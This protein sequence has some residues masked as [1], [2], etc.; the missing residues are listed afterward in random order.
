MATAEADGLDYRVG[1]GTGVLAGNY[2][3]WGDTVVGLSD[4]ATNYVYVEDP[5]A[6]GYGD[7]KADTGSFPSG[8]LELWEVVTSSG[9]VDTETDARTCLINEKDL[10]ASDLAFSDRLQLFDGNFEYETP[11]DL[12]TDT[13]TMSDVAEYIGEL[14]LTDTPTLAD[15]AAY[16]GLSSLSDTV[17]PSDIYNVYRIKPAK[18]DT[19]GNTH[20]SLTHTSFHEGSYP[21]DDGVSRDRFNVD[22]TNAPEGS[23]GETVEVDADVTNDG[24]EKGTQDV[25]LEV[26]KL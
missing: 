18:H 9:A 15:A 19:Q 13:L 8:V 7:V 3:T 22:I 1:G 10:T 14:E 4:N 24:I 21:T 2:V 17:K 6:D 12:G 25:D 26:T 23:P 16:L 20:E 11:A 5:D